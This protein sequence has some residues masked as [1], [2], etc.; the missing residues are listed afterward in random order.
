MKIFL[1]YFNY[2]FTINFK[3]PI[4]IEIYFIFIY[5]KKK[6]HLTFFRACFFFGEKLEVTSLGTF[7]TSTNMTSAH[8]HTHCQIIHVVIN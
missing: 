1:K 2:I 5:L 3:H 4:Y 6:L 7:V 8:W